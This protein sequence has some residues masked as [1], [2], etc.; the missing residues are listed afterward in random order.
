MAAITKPLLLAALALGL[1]AFG[2][3]LLLQRVPDLRGA[4]ELADKREPAGSQSSAQLSTVEFEQVD[5]VFTP[6]KLRSFAG[7][8][9][10]K[11]SAHVEG[12]ALECWYYGVA[13]ARGAYQLCFENGR[14][15]T[16]VRYGPPG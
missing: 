5:S 7:E 15:S 11:N 4:I 10:T 16:K 9:A 3:P 2:A 12:V 1:I 6:T 13:G 14:L 8:P